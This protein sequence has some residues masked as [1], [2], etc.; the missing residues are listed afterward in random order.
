MLYDFEMVEALAK[1][2]V[3]IFLD[4][5]DP[6]RAERFGTTPEDLRRSWLETNAMLESLTVRAR[7]L[8]DFLWG[9]PPTPERIAARRKRGKASHEHDVLARAV[10]RQPG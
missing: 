9:V 10:L 3:D 5:P 6:E 1:R 7:A 4:G 2:L 8:T